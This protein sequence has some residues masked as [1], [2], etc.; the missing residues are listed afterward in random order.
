MPVGRVV[1]GLVRDILERRGYWIRH[2][3][4]LPF[5]IDYQN[6]I[7]RLANISGVSIEVF[8]DVGA[9]IGQT[10]L[11]ARKNF[12]D[13]TI[14]AFEPHETTFAAL[15]AN[16]IGPR[17][18]ALNLALSDRIGEAEFFDYGA[19]ATSN[20]LVGD[21]QYAMRTKHEVTVRKVECDTLDNFCEGLGI[22]HIDVL[23]VDTEGHDLAVLQ[24]ARR[25]L[26]QHRIRSIYVEFNTLG[27]KA[28]T[29]GGALLPIS[30]M[31]EPLG[32]RFIASYAEYMITTGELF[33]TSN[34]L[35]VHER[36]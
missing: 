5:G 36:P 26:S 35:F 2:R 16:V 8:F 11:E 30:T 20:S 17:A 19:L 33:V 7:R 1:R 34:A 12:P 6:D 23:K 21:A 31:L 9:N 29:T 3:S 25:M 10:S 15:S 18:H 32:F 13:A 24:G 22:E 28:G 27:P 4:V 14:Y